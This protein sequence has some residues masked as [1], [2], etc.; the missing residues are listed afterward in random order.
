MAAAA[1][2]PPTRT[3]EWRHRPVAVHTHTL[4]LGLS[5]VSGAL[6]FLLASGLASGLPL[7]DGAF[8]VPFI[9]ATGVGAVLAY[10]FDTWAHALGLAI[11]LVTLA[12]TF[13]FLFGIFEPAS[14]IEFTGGVAYVL[15]ILLTF[16]GGVASLVRR[17]DVRDETPHSELLLDRTALGIVVLALVVSLPLWLVNRTTVD[18]AAAAGLPEV[19]AANFTFEDVTAAA[20]GA[21]VVRNQDPFLHTFTVDELGID[22]KLLPGDSTIVELPSTTGSWTYYCIPHSFDAGEGEDDMAATLTIE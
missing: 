12:M 1:P 5:L 13:F 18:A 20:G 2:V 7:S 14:F 22:V 9:A 6:A 19:T 3:S 21:L 4:V 10:R 11:G 16:Y 17:A 15:G 8:L